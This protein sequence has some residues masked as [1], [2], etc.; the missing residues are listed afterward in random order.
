MQAVSALLYS[1]LRN[2]RSPAAVGIIRF[3][4]QFRVKN[5]NNVMSTIIRIKNK[6][7]TTA[8]FT[9]VLTWFYF[10]YL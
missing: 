10:R 2:E 4:I 6:A 7:R 3:L 9:E 8:Q 5:R 1:S